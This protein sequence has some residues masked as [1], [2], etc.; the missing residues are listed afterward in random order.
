MKTTVEIWT[1]GAYKPTTDQGGWAF[2]CEN[3]YRDFNGVKNTTNNRM[4]MTAVIEALKYFNS[5]K[6]E[7][8]TIYSDSQYVINTLN[9]GWKRSKNLD[10]WK[11]LDEQNKGN[12]AFV[13][14]KGHDDNEMN[15]KVDKLAVLGSELFLI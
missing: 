11:A 14:V 3:G 2:I 13:W 9:K 1:D 12:I 5:L 7:S 6:L 4:E 10:L 8:G 15:N